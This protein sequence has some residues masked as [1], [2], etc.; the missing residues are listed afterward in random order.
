MAPLPALFIL[1][2]PSGAGKTTLAQRLLAARADLAFSVSHTTRPPRPGDVPGSSYHF[3]DRPTFERLRAADGFLEWAEVH[4][5]L[6]GT[7]VAEVRRIHES[8]RHA[9]LD[10][11]V[12]GA[13]QVR[14]RYPDAISVF[15]APP[16]L[17]VLAARLRARGSDSEDSVR[18]R[19]AG[20]AHEI[21]AAGEYDYIIVN[22][23][24]D[25]AMA[26]LLSTV[27]AALITA[28]RQAAQLGALQHE[29]ALLQATQ[30]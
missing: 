12:Q 26:D 24:L 27:R 28:R 9:L 16:S 17:A 29:A 14:A 20:A 21:L 11:D 18:R 2:A 8:G 23:E 6:Y 22:D 3:V 1:S 30:A 7:A 15:I 19:L 5:Q 25:R 4:G 10:I 13:R